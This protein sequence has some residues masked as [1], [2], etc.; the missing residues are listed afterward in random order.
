MSFII[1]FFTWFP[2]NRKGNGILTRLSKAR[3]SVCSSL[4]GW[5]VTSDSRAVPAVSPAW[6]AGRAGRAGTGD[7]PAMPCWRD[8]PPHAF[9]AGWD[10]PPAVEP[11]LIHSEDLRKDLVGSRYLPAKA[12]LCHLD[13]QV[14]SCIAYTR[15]LNFRYSTCK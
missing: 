7:A 9:D 15:S 14:V 2:R 12:E 3:P 6:P 1:F 8:V 5:V 11:A 4:F 10:R 13:I